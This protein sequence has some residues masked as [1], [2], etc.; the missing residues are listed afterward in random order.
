MPL[1]ASRRFQFAFRAARPAAENI[2]RE[3]KFSLLLAPITPFQLSPEELKN[4]RL[5]K[6]ILFQGALSTAAS[7]RAAGSIID[8]KT[9]RAPKAQIEERARG[10]AGQIAAYSHAMERITGK[11]V[12]SGLVYFFAVDTAVEV[13][14]P[15]E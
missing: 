12:A 5:R 8:F 4:G 9:D 15:A 13:F 11:P 2:W 6:T 3:F 7:R 1:S 10:Y 14:S